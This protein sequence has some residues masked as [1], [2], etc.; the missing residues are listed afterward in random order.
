MN[1]LATIQQIHGIGPHPNTE[2][3]R[4]EIGKILEWPVVI[5]KGEYQNGTLVVFIE[6]DSI[7][8]ESNPYFEFMRRQKFRVWNAKFK[9]APSSG[10]VCPL[11][12]LPPSEKVWAEG[13]DVTELLGILKYER[14]ID[15]SVGGETI[16]GF[17]TNLISISDEDN[18]LSHATALSELSDG[19]EIYISQKVDGSSGTFIYN[20]GEFQACSRRLALKEGSGFPWRAVEKYDIKNKLIAYNKNLAIQVEVIGP[21]LNGNSMELKEL[22]IKVFRI[23]N[24]DTRQCLGLQELTETCKHFEIPMVD[25]IEVCLFNKNV[26]TVEYFRK[27]ADSQ[28]WKTNNK[29]GEGIVIQPTVPIYSSI[30]GKNW[31]AK[32]INQNYK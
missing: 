27:M 11:S 8:P 3:E 25:I 15:F 21:K 24:L 7:V 6:I 12:I 5:P 20:N 18:L 26:H 23:K 30:L 2:V 19:Q 32:L 16:G 4:L 28:T 1:K 13:D 17:P 22:E 10:L 9:G 29:P 31:S 14:P